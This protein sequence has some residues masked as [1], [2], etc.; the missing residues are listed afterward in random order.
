V[1][2][3]THQPSG[4]ADLAFSSMAKRSMSFVIRLCPSSYSFASSGVMP[5]KTASLSNFL[6]CSFNCSN[7]SFRARIAARLC[8][9]FKQPARQPEIQ[10]VALGDGFC[11]DAIQRM[12]RENQDRLGI[13]TLTLAAKRLGG[14]YKD[15]CNFASS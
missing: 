3:R 8:G 10:T 7:S 12:G 9:V 14:E 13:S 4:H 5:P 6:C 11:V 15:S 2:R 1:L